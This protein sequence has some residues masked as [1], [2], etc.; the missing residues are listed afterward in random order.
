MIQKKKFSEN[1]ISTK[2]KSLKINNI[3]CL[4]IANDLGK[5]GL[6]EGK[7]K[8]YLL[9]SIYSN[10]IN[11]NPKITIVVPTA[12]LNFI[13]SD[14]VFDLNKTPCYQMGAFSEYVRNLKGAKRSFNPL[15]SLTAIGPLADKIV[16]NVSTHAYDDNSS[17]AKLFKIENS[18]FLSIGQHPR[19]MLSI[20]H[21]FEHIYKVPYRFTKEFKINYV[22][23]SKIITT[24]FKLDVLKEEFRYSKRSFNKKI[25][26]NFEK[27]NNFYETSL[28]NGIIYYFNLKDFYYSTCKL[29]E[30]DI[31]CWWK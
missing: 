10:L 22:K 30:K 28:G 18:Y 31:N 9:D 13:N 24:N 26:E 4:F 1:E 27:K 3:N 8:K 15:W 12:N 19:F 11:L 7:N 6:I 20:I 16:D 21:Y 29:F 17:F 5:I 25:F 23:N 14:E 2:F